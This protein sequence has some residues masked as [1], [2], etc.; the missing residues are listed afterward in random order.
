M[1]SKKQNPDRYLWLRNNTWYLHWNIPRILRDDPFFGGRSIF[2]KSL[3]TEDVYEARKMR[4][5][6]VSKFQAMVTAKKVH[7]RRAIFIAAYAEA[8]RAK[9]ELESQLTYLDDFAAVDAYDALESAFNVESVLE[10][11]NVIKADAY[12]AAIH[13]KTELVEKYSITL[14]EASWGFIKEHEGKVAKATLS[15]VKNATQSLI[16]ASG[17]KDLRLSEL[18]RR[19][20][21]RWINSISDTVSDSTRKGYIAALQKMW[22]WNWL[23]EHVEGESP[24]KGAKIEYQGDGSSY[25]EFT[26]GEMAEIVRL[27]DP[28]ERTLIRFGLVTGCRLSELI[29][30]NPDSFVVLE[31]VT[32]IKTGKGKTESSDRVLPLPR[33]LWKELQHCVDAK[34]WPGSVDA[35]SQRFGKLKLRATGKRDRT[36]CFHS[37]RHM[38][39]TAYDRA[40]IEERFTSALLGHKNK[41]TDSLSYSLYSSGL[42]IGQ[43]LQAVETMLA[44]DYMSQFLKLFNK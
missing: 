38:T 23:H 37:F 20:V 16:A 9:K 4:D 33:H 22:D 34:M 36:K 39:A 17:N 30:L 8:S 24:F 25:K 26:L 41:K 14:E 12:L 42:T 28:Q 27:A 11:G 7:T 2:S 21:T 40:F 29:G 1:K 32:A 19:Q 35:W 31:G 6:M 43:Y 13:G 5:L 10:K 44:S 18:D 3:Q 15:R